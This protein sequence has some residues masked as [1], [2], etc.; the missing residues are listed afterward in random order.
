MCESHL[1]RP[2]ASKRAASRN[3]E[4]SDDEVEWVGIPP[5]RG[6]ASPA[7][8]GTATTAGASSAADVT[9]IAEEATAAPRRSSRA[10]K[11]TQ[12]FHP[13]TDGN[14]DP[15]APQRRQRTAGA[16]GSG[17][18]TAVD[19]EEE[20]EENQLDQISLVDGGVLRMRVHPCA[21][22]LM[23]LHVH[24]SRTEVIGYLA[25]FVSDGLVDVAEAFPALCLNSREMARSGRSALREVEMLP[26]SDVMLRARIASKGLQVVGWYHSHPDARFTT[27]PSRVDIE[28]QANYQQY[29]FRDSPF[30][31]AVLAP[32]NSDLPDALGDMDA[33]YVAP[34]RATPMRVPYTIDYAAG[35][36]RSRPEYAQYYSHL[37][38]RDLPDQALEAEAVTLVLDL[39][40]H[41]QRVHL[42]NEWRPGHSFADKLRDCLLA[43]L[44][45]PGDDVTEEISG[46]NDR[47]KALIAQFLELINNSWPPAPARK[48]PA[49]R[50]RK[51]KK[52]F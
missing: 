33:F 47:L 36:L 6:A 4:Q 10:R 9:I 48:N 32:Y 19:E 18:S 28:N 13:L 41:R 45:K 52:G 51:R 34:D 30:I 15:R 39:A 20:E 2:R 31:A 12:P 43:L 3:S 37:A 1:G 17:A 23:H 29:I 16:S 49:G 38:G 22:L 21:A 40:K 44:P 7:A 24:L 42:L 35:D 25:G 11:Q 14:T 50:K 8:T 5:L 46:A 27:E 26:E